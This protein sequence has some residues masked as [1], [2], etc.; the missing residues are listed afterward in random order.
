MRRSGPGSGSTTGCRK[1]LPRKRTARPPR[2]RW[3]RPGPGP[4]VGLPRAHQVG[5][6]WGLARV[7]G[8]DRH[9]AADPGLPLRHLDLRGRRVLRR[10]DRPAQAGDRAGPGD[11]RL[12]RLPPPRCPE[13][14]RRSPGDGDGGRLGGGRGAL[15]RYPVGREQRAHHPRHRA[16]AHRRPADDRPRPARHLLRGAPHHLCGSATGPGSQPMTSTLATTALALS[17]VILEY[18][19][20]TSRVTALDD[21]TVTV[22]PGEVAAIVGPSGSG[23]SSLLAV[24]GALIRPTRGR[25]SVGGG[26]VTAA[27]DQHRAREIVTLLAAQAHRRGTATLLV[28]HDTGLLD[29]ADRVVRIRDGRLA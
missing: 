9:D 27:L 1:L 10:L 14:G 2:S 22:E 15:R 26:D 24:A 16:A 23:K 7:H 13:P 4:G 3:T 19:D 25:V 5:R 11:R 17:G 21:V 28:T 18:G 12:G 29:A 8:R 6:L 20:C